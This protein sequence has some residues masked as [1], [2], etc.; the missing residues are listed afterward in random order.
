[1]TASDG[2]ATDLFGGSVAISGD[3]GRVVIGARYADVGGN[4][5]Q[6]AAYVYTFMEP[7]AIDLLSF[8]AQ[9]GPDHVTLAW[10]TAGEIDNE[11]FNLWRSQ[12]A[13]GEY[14]KINPSLIPAQGNP[15]TGA[16]YEYVDTNVVK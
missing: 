12:A 10:E 1:M 15:D 5:N 4:V 16:S 9:A 8:T 14:A 11:G 7:T 6:G 3:A 13:D 2:A